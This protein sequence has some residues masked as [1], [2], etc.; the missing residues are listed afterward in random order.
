[1]RRVCLLQKA[2]IDMYSEVL[3]ELAD[4]DSSY[5]TADHLP[6]VSSSLAS[7]LLLYHVMT[8]FSVFVV[9]YMYM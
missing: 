5:R 6:R 8:D 7:R 3:D 9:Y 2:L 4:Y 1:M